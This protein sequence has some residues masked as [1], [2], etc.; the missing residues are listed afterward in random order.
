MGFK[1]VNGFLN[2]FDSDML[3]FSFSFQCM[4]LLLVPA[5]LTL[6]LVE[7]KIFTHSHVQKRV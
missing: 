7:E 2:I 5:L 1:S 6:L 4:S 3:N